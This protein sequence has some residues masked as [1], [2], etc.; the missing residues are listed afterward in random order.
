ML[1][2]HLLL[3]S[4]Q[5]PNADVRRHTIALVSTVL[6][7]VIDAQSCLAEGNA[8]MNVASCVA[9]LCWFSLILCIFQCQITTAALLCMCLGWFYCVVC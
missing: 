4:L 5:T 3:L 6:Q 9:S 1:C 2:Y 8:Y 7:R